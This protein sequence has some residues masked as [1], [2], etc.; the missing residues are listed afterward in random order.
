MAEAQ[1][2]LSESLNQAQ[3]SLVG[4]TGKFADLKTEM[5][6]NK[7]VVDDLRAALSD[8]DAQLQKMTQ[9]R[10]PGTAEFEEKQFQLE[11]QIKA[12]ELAGMTGTTA[13]RERAQ[14]QVGGL[15]DDLRRMQLEWQIE[16]DPQRR[17]LTE[18]VAGI[19]G[20][21][22]ETGFDAAM[23]E[24][25]QLGKERIGI[26]AELTGAVA[27]QVSL[28]R[29]VTAQESMVQ[30]LTRLVDRLESQPVSIGAPQQLPEEAWWTETSRGG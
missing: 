11:Q 1:N 14:K 9:V 18:K 16:T 24:A 12:A 5:E 7:N 21:R 13:A 26:E 8:V 15:R 29:S 20:L 22:A 19:Q 4:A 3:V 2:I 30:Q 6:A 28:E 25:A 27:Y 17:A 10:L 23:R